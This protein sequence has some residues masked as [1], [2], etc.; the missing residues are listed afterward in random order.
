MS[1]DRARRPAAHDVAVVG[2]GH[3]GGQVAVSLTRLGHDV[4]AV[5][6]DLRVVQRWAQELTYVV[7]A[8]A[9]DAVALRQLGLADFQRVVVAIGDSVEA[10]VLTVLA[11][12]ELGV[13][14][15]WA[16]ATSDQHAR[17]L[18]SVGARHVVFPEAAMGERV[19]HLIV[20]RLLDFVEFDRDFAI[21]KTLAPAAVVGRRVGEIDARDGHGVVVVGVRPPDG[22]RFAYA[23]PDT[24]ITPGCVLVI[25]GTIEQVQRFAATT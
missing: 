16:R 23:G 4:L 17:I 20:S 11:V 13:P 7:Q 8:D 1:A 12:A 15:I 10:S 9:T 25:E 14:Q 5:D 2:L 3:F 21:A 6:D 19:A 22:G 24:V 18:S